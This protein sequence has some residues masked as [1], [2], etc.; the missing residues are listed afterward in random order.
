MNNR[1]LRYHLYYDEDDYRLLEIVNKIL[2]R[3]RNPALLR[4][5]FE[6]GLHPRGIKELAAAKSLRVACAMIDLLGTFERGSAGERLAALRAVRAETLHESSHAL[7]MNVARVLMQIMKEIVRAGGHE[8]RQLELARDFREASSGKARLIRKQLH[9]YHLLEMPEAWNQLAFDH[10]VHD[11]NTKGR[12]S[13]THLIMDAWIKGVRFLGVIYY[14]DVKPEV[15]A[16]LLEAAAVMGVD[17]RIGV[18]VK[19]RLRNK[20]VQIIWS[21]RGFLG[22]EDFLRFLEE[23]EVEAFL[24]QGRAVVEYERQ[25]VLELLR[26]FN[27]NHLPTINEKLGLAVLPLQEEAFISS[28]GCGQASLV[29]LAEYAHQMILPHLKKRTEDLSEV[30]KNASETERTRIGA[31]VNSFDQLAPETLVEEYLRP[32]ANPT[33]LDPRI[34]SD[35]EDVPEMLRFDTATMI[36]KLEQLPCRSR[37]TLNPSNLSPADVLEVLYDGKGRVTHIEIYNLKDWAQGRTQHRLLIN[38]M[39]LVINSGNV[40]E[41]KRMVREILA[42][43]ENGP[44]DERTVEKLRII[45]RDLKTLLGFYKGSRLRSR[46]GSDSIG[47]SRHTRGMGLVVTPSLPWRARREIRRDPSRVLPVTTVAR[48][49]IMAGQSG[50]P[51]IRQL[52]ARRD[53]AADVLEHEQKVTW[54]VGHNSTTLATNGNIASLGG[55]P[56]RLSNGLSLSALVGDGTQRR[57]RLSHLNSGLMNIAKISLGFLPAFFTFYLTKDWWLLAYFGALIWFGITG[58]RNVLQSVVGGGGVWRSSLLKW[59]KLVS[60]DRVADSLMFTGFS[61]P[62]LDF[63]VKDVVLA[64][65]FGITTTSSPIL[66][67]SFMALINGVYVSSHNTFRGLPLGAIIG[68]FFRSILSI[69]VALGLNFVILHFITTAG[70]STEVALADMQLWAAIISKAASD[71]VAAIIEGAVDRQHNFSHRK[72]DYQEKLSQIYD[73]FE[74]LETT[75]PEQDVLA[76][77][78]RSHAFAELNEKNPDLLRDIVIDS[79]DLLYFW[80]YQPRARATL[81]KQMEHMSRDE[82]RFLLQSQQVLK[83]KRIVSEMLLN[84]LVGKRFEDAL[85]FYLSHADRYLQKFARLAVRPT[86]R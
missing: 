61:V 52:H 14:N 69:P 30:Y 65:S 9:K 71:T 31:L 26:S 33:V 74:R 20:Y 48:R 1:G 6:P 55:K 27:K 62:L 83:Q 84:G 11:A 60:W 53:L 57:P 12:K 51:P 15:A 46:L 81:L 8:K 38:E 28:V 39:R 13:P 56:E 2:S 73:V 17:V 32:E 23:P 24:A 85:A 58:L 5:L 67:Y 18:E 54:S 25:R 44:H 86:P 79:L 59:K 78:E 22:H 40:V 4:R 10:H 63:L 72:I 29:H 66:L 19:A 76:L 41:A 42:S 68:N 47:H 7:R 35:G 3:G 64:R 43:V 34:P 75:F 37:I 82:K 49:Q 77:L 80:M 50:S 16:E 36:A 70:V 45:L 21:P